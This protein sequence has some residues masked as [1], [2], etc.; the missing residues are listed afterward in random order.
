M[1][2]TLVFL[3]ILLPV[4]CLA[5]DLPEIRDFDLETT[6]EL[7]KELYR[8]DQYAARATDILF[9][10]ELDLQTYP[11][12]G[13]IVNLD[14]DGVLVTFIGEYPNGLRG[15]FDIRPDARNERRFEISEERKLSDEEL[16][17][18]RAR[19][20]AANAITAPCSDR[21][22]SVVLPD[23]KGESWLVYQLPATMDSDLIL[24][25]GYYRVTIS[26]DG[27]DVLRSDRL[28]NSCLTLTKQPA[29][30]PSGATP[31]MMFMTH[32]LSSTPIE[33][34]V[35][36]SLLHEMDFAVSTPDGVIW[37]VSGEQISK[38]DQ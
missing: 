22:N 8:I 36:L 18:F 15:I 7:G 28:S 10:Q 21:Y 17:R 27:N 11:V 12:V 30:M 6:S 19:Q 24:V 3:L 31:V 4:L 1:R 20:T 14:D 5:D 23:P 34:H 16:A 37:K 33:T 32:L 9:E 35:F 26:S 38:L 25:G 13:W 29:D 2:N